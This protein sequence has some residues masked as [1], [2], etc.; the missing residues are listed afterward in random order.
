MGGAP[1]LPGWDIVVLAVPILSL[2]GMMMFGLDERCASPQRRRGTRR[3]FCEVGNG[4]ALLS[5]PDGRLWQGGGVI[6]IEA[7]L[8]R[9][10]RSGRVEG[11]PGRQAVS[12]HF[13]EIR[14]YVVERR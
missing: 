13:S 9:G 8:I 7:R 5:D 14:G 10:V 3:S 2:L 12:P 1:V 11:T 6:Q 4:P